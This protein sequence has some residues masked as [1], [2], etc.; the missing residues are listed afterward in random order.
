MFNLCSDGR[1]K[2]PILRRAPRWG[3]SLI[4][5]IIAMSIFAV[6]AAGIFSAIVQSSMMKEAAANELQATMLLNN[7]MEH[8]R[9]L[10]WP[11]VTA[12]PTKATFSD[13]QK[14]SKF[15]TVRQISTPMTGQREVQ[16]TITWTDSK[17]KTFTASV[18]TLLT[19]YD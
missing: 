9:A 4:E 5:I 10:D 11:E 18:V 6:T 15:S 19:E 16:L 3:F 2:F 7:E 1:L 14:G 13:A 17:D 8:L 12:L